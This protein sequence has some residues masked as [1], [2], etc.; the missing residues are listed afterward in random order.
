MT[1]IHVSQAHQ[2]QTTVMGWDYLPSLSATENLS[3]PS[4]RCTNSAFPF[5]LLMECPPN[6]TSEKTFS[7][8]QVQKAATC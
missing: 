4:V 5:R 6:G 8:E 1:A 7:E 2:L 3:S